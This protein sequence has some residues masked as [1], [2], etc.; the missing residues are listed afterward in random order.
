MIRIKRK[1]QNSESSTSK[2]YNETEFNKM[3]KKKFHPKF[4]GKFGIFAE[5]RK[6]NHPD[7]AE[8]A[9]LGISDIENLY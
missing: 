3:Q 9:K 2:T 5:I 4:L 7:Q 8:T 1:P 6:N